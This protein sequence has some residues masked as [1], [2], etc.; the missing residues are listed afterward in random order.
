VGQPLLRAYSIGSMPG[1]ADS[2][3]AE[4]V[5]GRFQGAHRRRLVF[6]V[7][8]AV[9]VVI[10]AFSWLRHA[11]SLGQVAVTIVVA[12]AVLGLSEWIFVRRVGVEIQRDGLVLCGAVRK[13]PV[14]WAEVKGFVWREARSL[15]KTEYLYVETDYPTP[16]R[17]PKD[18]PIRL[19]TVARTTNHDHLNDRVLGPL[20]T[21]P[22]LRS[23]T[24]AEADAT[25]ILEHAWRQAASAAN[26]IPAPRRI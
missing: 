10:A 24:G 15:A 19:P 25:E 8:G 20:L 14:P 5:Y 7:V 16:R 26:A 4:V 6:T 18:A 12:L 17:I 21:S 23:T 1:K 11:P 13:T 3:R 2:E 22:N 9:L